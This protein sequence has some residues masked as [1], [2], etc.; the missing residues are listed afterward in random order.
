MP[1]LSP[2]AATAGP[3]IPAPVAAFPRHDLYAGIHKALRHFMLDTLM[4]AAIEHAGAER[5]VL[6]LCEGKGPRVVAE[7]VTSAASPCSSFRR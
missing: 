2:L 7:A 5:A 4:R 3:A 6:I 1:V